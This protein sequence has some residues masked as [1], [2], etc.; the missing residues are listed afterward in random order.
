MILEWLY[1]GLQ[2]HLRSKQ[3]L[4]SSRKPGSHNL[5]LLWQTGTLFA[6]RARSVSGV[7]SQAVVV[8]SNRID[9]L[10][11]LGVPLATISVCFVSYDAV[12]NVFFRV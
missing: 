8:L 5:L 4:E 6:E 1:N 3:S 11:V 12:R 7:D 9:L 10:A 2:R